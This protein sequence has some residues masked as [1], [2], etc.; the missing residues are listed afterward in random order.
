MSSNVPF[1]RVKHIP[2]KSKDL[3]M[4]Y[5]RTIETR[6]PDAVKLIILLF[7]YNII[8]SSILTDEESDTLL[9]LCEEKNKF[10]DLPNYSF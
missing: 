9:R 4:G 2:I 7:Y 5:I 1:Q 6:I 8:K 10:K 3:I